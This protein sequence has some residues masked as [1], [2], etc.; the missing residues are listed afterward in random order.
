MVEKNKFESGAHKR[1]L[2]R[3]KQQRK[4]ELLK[5]IPKLTGF[6]KTPTEDD[7][8]P[9]VSSLS[10]PPEA[11]DEA[12][13]PAQVEATATEGEEQ[14]SGAEEEEEKEEEDTHEHQRGGDDGPYSSDPGRWGDD[15]DRQQVRAYWAKMGPGP[16]QNKSADLSASEREYQHQRRFFSKTHF[17]RKL[18][19]GECVSREWLCYSPS[20]SSVFCFACKIFGENKDK[21]AFV[22]GGYS[23]WKHA[24]DRIAEHESSDI[25]RKAMIAY[26]NQ[27][28]DCGTVD[29]ELKKQFNEECQYW[30]QVLQ[31]VV[32]VVKYL[33]ERGL[34]FRGDSHRF[35]DTNNG[36]Y[37]G[38]MELI[39]QFDPFLKA[40]IGKIWK[41]W[42]RNSILPLSECV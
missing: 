34:P 21:S 26:I 32:T 40:H 33:A 2:V 19:N 10:N 25:H 13:G 17:N 39:S 16:S 29:S 7:S 27:A 24:G 20:A 1:K 35:G 5:S 38:S 12:A 3:E 14:R 18:S 6:F 9:T 15:F 28:A 11:A 41:R 42:Q 22:S 8:G 36:N 4:K 31:R 30:T 23:D 37:L